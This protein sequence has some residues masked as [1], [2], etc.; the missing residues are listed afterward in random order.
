MAKKKT[1]KTQKN[2]HHSTTV[3][4]STNRATRSGARTLQISQ[5]RFSLLLSLPIDLIYYLV[6]LLSD[7]SLLSLMQTNSAFYHLLAP[8]MTQRF[9]SMTFAMKTTHLSYG[10]VKS[11]IVDP[12]R[13]AA[14]HGRADLVER[15]MTMPDRP[16]EWDK[17]ITLRDEGSRRLLDRA[18]ES[19]DEDTVR[20]LI[21]AYRKGKVPDEVFSGNVFLFCNTTKIFAMVAEEASNRMTRR[22]AT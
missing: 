2:N 10:V 3:L 19:G 8:T 1:A 6:D 16:K 13:W 17:W 15:I 4:A 5:P 22:C 7:I 21:E 14:T 18:A 11:Y 20:V 12:L 9:F